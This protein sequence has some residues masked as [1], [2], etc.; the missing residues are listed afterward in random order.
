MDSCG[1]SRSPKSA[2]NSS[3]SAANAAPSSQ[4]S[5]ARSCGARPS[6]GLVSSSGSVMLS[7][8]RRTRSSD[9]EHLLLLRGELLVGED[10]ARVQFGE[11]YEIVD[12][13]GLRSRW[14][15]RFAVL[16][17]GCLQRVV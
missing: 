17:G 5:T 16:I 8:V 13:G 11:P 2:M 9:P 14:R 12:R 1:A 10:A 15:D 6:L 4:P 7:S 3:A